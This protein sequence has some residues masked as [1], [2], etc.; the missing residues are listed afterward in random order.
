MRCKL[1]IIFLALFAAVFQC[2]NKKSEVFLSLET[3]DSL[4]SVDCDSLAALFFYQ[5]DMPEDTT[6]ELSYYNYVM[7]RISCRNY[8]YQ[9]P[10][11]LDLPIAMFKR[12]G[13]ILRLA[14]S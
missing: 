10:E 6:E 3:T 4:L 2:C 12:N 5:I 9:D 11:I 13:D 1:Y 14:Y 7:S 8:E